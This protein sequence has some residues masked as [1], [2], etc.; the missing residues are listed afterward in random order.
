MFFCLIFPGF[1]LAEHSWDVLVSPMS[2]IIGFSSDSQTGGHLQV[3]VFGLLF[4]LVEQTRSVQVLESVFAFSRNSAFSYGFPIC[5]MQ[6][7][8]LLAGPVHGFLQGISHFAKSLGLLIQISGC[9]DLAVVFLCSCQKHPDPLSQAASAVPA[10]QRG[11]SAVSAA[12][13]LTDCVILPPNV[14]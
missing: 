11:A 5:S 3:H 9:V 2:K 10:S 7:S 1:P 4:S 6:H 8:G 14:L 13:E 12:S